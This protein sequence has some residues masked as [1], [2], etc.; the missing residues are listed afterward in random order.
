MAASNKLL[1]AAAL[2]FLLGPAARGAAD[3]SGAVTINGVT[4]DKSKPA[5]KAGAAVYDDALRLKKIFLFPAV[6]DM[7]G[8]LSAKLDEKLAQL[9]GRDSRFNLVRDPQVVKA[10]SPDDKAYGKATLSP[11]VHR[12]AA[13]VTG[14][15]TTAI[16]RSRNVGSETEMTLEL[17]DAQG[18]LLF[19]ETGGI[20]G[21]SPM[22]ARWG[23]I[24][25]L[26]RS[27]LAKIPF[28]GTV[29]GRSAKTV[30]L[31]LGSSLVRP[32]EEVEIA[33]IISVQRHPLLGTIVGV[34]YVRIGK[35][36]ITTADTGLSFAEITEEHPGEVIG[37]GAKVLR[38]R[39]SSV[40]RPESAENQPRYESRRAEPEEGRDPFE[41]RL[42]GDFDTPRARYGRVGANLQYGSLSH[43]Q[44]ASGAAADYS[45]SGIGGGLEGEIW[46][47]KN[48][49]V[50]GGYGFHNASLSG[51]GTTVGD[52][53]WHKFEGFAGYRFFPEETSGGLT[54]TGSLGYQVQDFEL[55]TPAGTNVGAKRFAGPALRLTGEMLLLRDHKLSGGF[56]FQ[57]FSS[58][59]ETGASLGE[60]DGGTVIGF[61]LAWNYRLADM[62]WG[63]LGF[64]FETA[65]GGY[66][67]NNSVTDKRFAI[68]PGLYYSF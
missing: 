26:F 29:T 5:E 28:D 59:T 23:L 4:Y 30:T 43:S 64:E 6:D 12:E 22:S 17:R 16:L 45:G 53:S 52:T 34:D 8:V 25:K 32:G 2:L 42:K 44:A 19:S 36:R 68:G 15:D 31:D 67:N 27:F 35:A 7:N 21:L 58:L 18:N 11:E 61:H 60:P 10:L 55:P 49:I 54:L 38:T 46:V 24:E 3:E 65:S 50:S 37:P 14:A 20:P 41:D 13:R 47:T 1:A 57:P 40:H 51:G 9:F 62:L 66:T 56:G 39:T 33:R 48:W 63:R